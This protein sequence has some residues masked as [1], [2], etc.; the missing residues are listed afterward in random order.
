MSTKA[1]K[2]T[3][4]MQKTAGAAQT[5]AR[6]KTRTARE[7]VEPDPAPATGS[8]AD[9]DEFAPVAQLLT[10]T[11]V[12]PMRA[13]LPLALH[14]VQV[15]VASVMAEETRLNELPGTDK[16]LLSSFPRLV[17]AAIFADTQIERATPPS[18]VQDLLRRGAALRA[19][20]L[21]SADSLAEAGLLPKA[22][23]DAI[24]AGHG[25][26]DSARDCIALAALFT[27]NAPGL[28]GKHPIT[29]AQL[30]DAS[31]TGTALLKVLKTGRSRRAPR[32]G[33]PPADMRDRLWTLVVR[34]YD[35]LWRVGAYLFGRHDVDDKVPPLQAT[36]G[37]R[38]SRPSLQQAHRPLRRPERRTSEKG[39]PTGPCLGSS[40]A[41]MASA[42]WCRRRAVGTH[43][44]SSR[45]IGT[46]LDSGSMDC[47]VGSHTPWRACPEGCACRSKR[48]RTSRQYRFRLA[49]R[50]AL[51]PNA[52]M[53]ASR[54]V[55]R[56]AAC[57][58]AT[59][60]VVAN[61]T[62]AACGTSN[63][64]L[65]HAWASPFAFLCA[66]CDCVFAAVLTVCVRSA[67]AL[68][69]LPPAEIPIRIWASCRTSE[70]AIFFARLLPVRAVAPGSFDR[71]SRRGGSRHP[72]QRS[73]RLGGRWA[74]RPTRVA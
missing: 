50:P 42:V 53:A 20:L 34:R 5:S 24:R 43:H 4:L 48:R 45:A 55:R 33:A 14:N 44:A 30:K 36:R 73:L 25:K 31:E 22:S 57:A 66:I 7:A 64:P 65:M 19:L 12:V 60:S 13:D 56:G 38:K 59:R 58:T 70:R 68:A 15:G 11:D 47:S 49:R 26:L 9:Y 28:R 63:E 62:R 6:S 16:A 3:K 51:P 40:A 39:A 61:A 27:K 1:R 67:S 10:D 17:L 8:Q 32:V 54:R 23:V 46:L 21:K 71:L 72:S 18:E 29:A 41:R 52:S 37:G 69:A 35:A 2:T 74:S